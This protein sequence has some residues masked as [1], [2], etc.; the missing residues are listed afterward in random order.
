[1][2]TPNM[3]TQVENLIA[4][5]QQQID[6]YRL[7]RDLYEEQADKWGRQLVKAK[8]HQGQQTRHARGWDWNE[9]TDYI[10]CS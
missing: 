4:R 10:K 2:L 3:I 8:A 7:C 5:Q 1:M 9:F 6:V